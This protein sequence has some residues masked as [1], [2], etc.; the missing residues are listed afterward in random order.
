[1]ESLGVLLCLWGHRL[2]IARDGPEALEL[3]ARDRPDVVFLDLSLPGMNG[4][5]VAQ[6]LRRLPGLARALVVVVS[7]YGRQEDR[8][9]SLTAGCDLHLI[10]PVDPNVLE[11]LLRGWEKR[12]ATL[13]V[14]VTP[15]PLVKR[16]GG[17]CGSGRVG[18]GFAPRSPVRTY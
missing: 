5:E 15:A 10:K 18:I 16:P 2:C 17:A 14:G 1:A 13:D 3:A 12:V 9:H 8:D 7:G 6:R 4:W 11:R